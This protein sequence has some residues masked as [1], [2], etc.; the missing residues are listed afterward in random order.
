V[1]RSKRAAQDPAKKLMG[2]R[3]LPCKIANIWIVLR[4]IRYAA[5]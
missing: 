2:L 1:F 3:R 4:F 5:M